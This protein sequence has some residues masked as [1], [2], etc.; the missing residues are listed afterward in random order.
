MAS[1][2]TCHLKGQ[3]EN[4]FKKSKI[5]LFLSTHKTFFRIDHVL[6]QKSRFNKFNVEI[7]SSY[8]S[9]CT[10][11]K[12]EINYRKKNGKNINL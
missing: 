7:I 9:D 2:N 4:P 6:G 5:T 10:G 8:L 3:D 1:N 11:M 12:L